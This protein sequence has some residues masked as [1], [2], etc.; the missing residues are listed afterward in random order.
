[1]FLVHKNT[2]DST[3]IW[4][5]AASD[6][7]LLQIVYTRWSFSAVIKFPAVPNSLTEYPGDM[8]RQFPNCQCP[9]QRIFLDTTIRVNIRATRAQYKFY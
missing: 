5:F 3:P 6:N 1:M 8:Y 7:P 4:Q 2:A 9:I